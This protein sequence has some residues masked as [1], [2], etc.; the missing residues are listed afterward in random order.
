M[1]AEALPRWCRRLLNCTAGA[2]AVLLLAGMAQSLGPDVAGLRTSYAG[3]PDSWPRPR[4]EAGADFAEFAPLPALPAEDKRLAAIGARLFDDPQLSRSKQ[5]ACSSCHARE[6]G[7]ADGLRTAFGHDRQRGKRN[8]QSLLTAGWMRPMFWDGRAATLEDQAL[9][10]ITDGVEMAASL[11][12]VERR[13][14]GDTSYRKAYAEIGH[15]GRITRIDIARALASFQRTL[16]PPR[17]QFDQVLTRGSAVL[18]DQQ[19][20]GLDLFR[21]KAGCANCHNGPLLSDGKFH[22]LGLSFYGRS[23]EDLGRWNVTHL[24]EDVG[25]FRTPSL[26]GI[27]RTAPYMHNGLFRTLDNVVAFY[28]GGGGRDRRNAASP[29]GAP[30]PVP[31]PLVKPL[32]LTPEERAALVAFLQTL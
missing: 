2:G 32:R 15:R 25:R 21:N 31:D 19:L 10:P 24:A 8:S 4:I 9:H 23:L 27:G 7:F 28:S 5:I 30:S 29:S 22:N 14:N 20:W 13:I 3:K 12:Q 17:S 11:G 26:R 18:T 6:L 1:E 16:R